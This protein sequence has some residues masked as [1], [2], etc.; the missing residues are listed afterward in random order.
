VRSNSFQQLRIFYQLLSYFRDFLMPRWLGKFAWLLTLFCISL[1]AAAACDLSATGGYSNNETRQL[2][3]A[4]TAALTEAA[5]QNDDITGCDVSGITN[6]DSLFKGIAAFNQDI[7]SWD[8]SNV[9]NMAQMFR[10]TG[11]NQDISGWDVSNVTNMARTFNQNS[12]FN[13]DISG[14]DVSS[15]TSFFYTFEYASA[16]NQDIRGWDVSSVTAFT[17]MFQ[18]A[19]AM[20]SNFAAPATPTSSFFGDT[21]APTMTITAAEVSDGDTSSDGTLS[22]TFTASEATSNFAVGDIT[23]TNGSISNF[24]STSS[25]VYTA[26]FTPAADGATTIDVAGGAFT[27]AAGN[28]NTAATQFNWTYSSLTDPSQKADVVGSL[29]SQ[30]QIAYQFHKSSIDAVNDRL[31]WLATRWGNS[32]NSKQGI[33]FKFTDPV[34]NQFVNSSPKRFRDYGETDLAT[35][36]SKLGSTPEFYE[37]VLMAKAVSIGLAELK[38]KTGGVDLNPE[39]GSASNGWSFWSNGE[40]S[41][42]KTSASTS[43]ASR[44]F[45]RTALT[46]GVDK[47]YKQDSLIGFA[48]L[49]GREDTDVGTDGSNVQSDNFGV[50]VYTAHRLEGLPQVETSLNYASL[51]LDTKRIDGS[52]TLTGERSGHVYSGSVKA[53]QFVNYAGLDNSYYAGLNLA[54]IKL[55]AFDES[56]GNRALRYFDQDIDYQE[57]DFGGEISKTNGWKGFKIRTYSKL[58]YSSV[59]N[60]SFPA[61][62]R[63]L[64]GSNIY[65][66]NVSTEL[67]TSGTLKLG[68]N[69]WKSDVLN[70]DF[71]AS[72]TE[73]IHSNDN[74]HHVNSINVGLRFRF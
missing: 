66:M 61:S 24:A 65:N 34:L 9:T 64:N 13:Q 57:L 49:V 27:D 6:M 5:R 14:W 16:F 2:I 53:R 33:R 30:D 25:T 1:K 70:V 55:E 37:D 35:L 38:A 74:D 72:R 58:Q 36:A 10:S 4:D 71:A 73:S 28:N 12:S 22:L 40:I 67:K 3:N 59:L 21:T 17:N 32:N 8:V 44:D 50:T 51:S 29:L 48:A 31:S 41:I 68:V 19:T 45:N 52:E 69:V 43:A 62:M 26:T 18:F 39:F 15:V 46:F 54:D 60:K 11:F 42:G 20:I 23:V 63:Y 56:G 47:E 7:S